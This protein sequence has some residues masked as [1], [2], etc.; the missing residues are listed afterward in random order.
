MRCSRRWPA[1]GSRAQKIGAFALVPF[2]ALLILHGINHDV[3]LFLASFA[4][5]FAALAG[6]RRH[7]QDARARHTRGPPG[8]CGV[9][10]SV[11]AV[12][13]DQP[14]D[15]SRVL[16]GDARGSSA[17]ASGRWERP[18]S[19]SR[20]SSDRQCSPR[21]LTTTSSPTSLRGPAGFRHQD[22]ASV[23][24][25]AD[26]RLRPRWLL[27]AHRL[28]AIG[29]GLRIHPAGPGRALQAGAMDPGDDTS[30]RQDSRRDGG[31]HL[32]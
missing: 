29:R 23:R 2:V 24:D 17:R 5:F 11:S 15:D 1:S 26:R 27:D 21:S 3:P 20:S 7:S 4:G 30:H 6:D 9:L 12:S 14:A 32:R 10:L 18:T 13:L 8:I 28:R 22:P 19:L 31:R 16:R 25:G